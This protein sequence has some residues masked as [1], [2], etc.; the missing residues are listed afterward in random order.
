MKSIANFTDSTANLLLTECK[1]QRN[2][3]VLPRSSNGKTT[4][5][6]SETA[7]PISAKLR[8]SDPICSPCNCVDNSGYCELC[9]PAILIN[10]GADF[11]KWRNLEGSTFQ[12]DAS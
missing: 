10:T 3:A 4:D 6:D 9:A 1:N 7:R 12:D 11:E 2:C 8:N 5:S